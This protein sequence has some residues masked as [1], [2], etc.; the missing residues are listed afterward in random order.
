[1]S[2]DLGQHVLSLPRS[3]RKR[4]TEGEEHRQ[5]TMLSPLGIRNVKKNESRNLSVLRLED[6]VELLPPLMKY[7]ASLL[8]HS[9]TFPLSDAIINDVIHFERL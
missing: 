4:E 2:G 8:E 6:N 7:H 5:L 9:I 1:M 3:M